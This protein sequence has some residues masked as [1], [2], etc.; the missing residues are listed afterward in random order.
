MSSGLEHALHAVKGCEP[1]EALVQKAVT[2]CFD[3]LLKVGAVRPDK[4]NLGAVGLVLL[5]GL[6]QGP[7]EVARRL[8][9]PQQPVFDRSLVAGPATRMNAQLEL[10][11][12]RADAEGAGVVGVVGPKRDD[13]DLIGMVPP[14]CPSGATV[15]ALLFELRPHDLAQGAVHV[16]VRQRVRHARSRSHL[17]GGGPTAALRQKR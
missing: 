1:C 13:I 14:R 8:L 11:G 17:N 7:P 5:E 4:P 12:E 16:L 6:H 2:R 3:N 15:E 9:R 10:K